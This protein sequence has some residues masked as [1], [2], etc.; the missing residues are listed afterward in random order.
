MRAFALALA[1]CISLV[2][3]AT[4]ASAEPAAST[5][6]TPPEQPP[7]NAGVVFTDNPSIVNSRP[8]QFD[9]WNRLDTDD[10]LALHF[11]VGSPECTSV[12]ATVHETAETVAIELRSGSLP[13]A[14]GRVCTMIAVLGT[15]DVELQTPLG[16]RTVRSVY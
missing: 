14:V 2:G 6:A 13:E 12:H 9:S 15:L 11:T 5:T 8:L 1:A 7:D 4:L 3:C 10:A 16:D